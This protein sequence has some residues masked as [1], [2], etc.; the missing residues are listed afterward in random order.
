MEELWRGAG[1]QFDPELVR[2]FEEALAL[3]EAAGN[4]WQ[5]TDEPVPA[6]DAALAALSAD[7]PTF[8]FGD[9]D[10]PQVEQE[11]YPNRIGSGEHLIREGV[12]GGRGG[13]SV[14]PGAEPVADFA[15][16]IES[17]EIVEPVEEPKPKPEPTPSPADGDA[18]AASARLGDVSQWFVRVERIGRVDQ[19]EGPE[20]PEELRTSDAPDAQTSPDEPDESRTAGELQPTERA[21]D[22]ATASTA[23]RARS[24]PPESPQAPPGSPQARDRVV[25]AQTFESALWHERLVAPDPVAPV[26]QFVWHDRFAGVDPTTPLRRRERFVPAETVADPTV[27]IAGFP[28]VVAPPGHPDRP[29]QGGPHSDG[30]TP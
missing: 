10:D 1:T 16:L 27:W 21:A 8:S 25:P 17:A 9:H 14:E 19:P 4:P 29:V 18:E 13:G 23:D 6:A 7:G 12:A 5:V 22:P 3:Q 20:A 30:P 11:W 2:A 15:E 24:G 26:D 28:P